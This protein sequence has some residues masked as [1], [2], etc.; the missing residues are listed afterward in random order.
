MSAVAPATLKKT[1]LELGL[2]PEAD[3][4]AYAAEAKAL[5][6]PIEDFLVE[7][8]VITDENLGALVADLLGAP[9]V[10]LNIQPIDDDVLTIIPEPVAR[11]QM[12][13][14]Y[15]RTADVVRLAMQDPA[16]L[17]FVRAVEKKTGLKASVAY[18]T[19]RDI[20]TVFSRYRKE[21]KAAFGELIDKHIQS[22]GAAYKPEDLPI[23]KI[24]DT[25]MAYGY[26]NRASDVHIEPQEKQTVVRFRVDGTLHDVVAVPK[27]LHELIIARIKILSKLKTDEHR[28]AQ[29]GKFQFR[30][31]GERVDVR[32]SIAPIIEGEKVVMRLLAGK[33]RQYSLEEIGLSQKDMKK[34]RKAMD[35]PFGMIIVSG[36]SGSGKTTTLYAM[37]KI[38]NEREVNI[39]TIEDPV[40][41]ELSGIN[42]IQVNAETNLTFAE[43]LKSIV[44][45]DPDIIMV[46]EIRDQ[47][48]ASIAANAALTGHLVLSTLHSNDAPTC[49]PRLLE[50]KVEPFLMASTI[51]LI[52]AQR[53]VRRVCPNCIQSYTVQ[54]DQLPENLPKEVR[55]AL[56]GGKRTVQLYKGNGCAVCNFRGTLGRVGIYETMEVDEAIRDLIMA[57]ASADV[58]RREAVRKGMDTMFEDGIAKVLAGVTTIEEVLDEI[59]P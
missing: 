13:V 48:T 16:N 59:A 51:S 54:E 35:R 7:K 18:A 19:R 46:G 25:I 44:R 5:N 21:L 28:A 57:R 1:L 4:E 10:R 2:V 9:F 24:V 36:P 30:S 15:A 38:L 17:E 22:A 3:F 12:A 50:M 20:E 41:Y 49:I 40:E 52:V 43:G 56:L 27:R 29:D 23:T 47:E 37:L 11:K 45:Q 53:L 34:A 33:S 6:E 32:V 55:K 8:N 14:A 42:Q 26:E 39:A 58:I 31:E